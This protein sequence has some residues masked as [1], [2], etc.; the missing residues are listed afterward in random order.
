MFSRLPVVQTA[1]QQ[2]CF[3]ASEPPKF[4]PRHLATQLEAEYPRKSSIQEEAQEMII[5]IG[6]IV[7]LKSG[8]PNM[9]VISVHP[10]DG[11]IQTS[12]FAGATNKTAFFHPASLD[13][14]KDAGSK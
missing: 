4:R 5:R 10:E 12:W 9:T 7:K 14:V 11:E 3:T 13:V 8:G 2:N 1:L 6:E